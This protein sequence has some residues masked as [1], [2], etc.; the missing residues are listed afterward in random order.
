MFALCSHNK[1]GLLQGEHPLILAQSDLPPVDLKV[2]DIR[3]QIAANGYRYR[4]GHN[5]EPIGNYHR[6]F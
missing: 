1:T 6:S 4:Y 3:S 5:G 2:G